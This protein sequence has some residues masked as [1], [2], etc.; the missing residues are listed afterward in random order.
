MFHAQHGGA[1]L[2]KSED[3]R[4]HDELTRCQHPIK[5]RTKL[6]GKRVILR[7]YVEKRNRHE[8]G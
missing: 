5:G 1:L 7:V 8:E 6:F 3:I 4:P 2:L